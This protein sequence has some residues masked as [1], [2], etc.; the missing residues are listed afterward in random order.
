MIPLCI[1][2]IGEEELAL[3]EQV[4]K[5]GWLTHGLYNEQ[6]EQEFA[7]YLG[8]KR[9]ISMNSCTSALH[10]AIEAQG[11]T[12]EVI[13]PSFTFV[14]SAN[15]VITGG[16]TPVFADIEYETC[17]VDPQSIEDKLTPQTE[18]IM[19]VHFGG[20]SC[21]M[22]EIMAIAAK[23][24]LAVIEDAAETIG[25]EYKGRKVGSFATGC[26]SFFPTKNITTG[27]GG[28]LTTDDESLA[29]KVRAYVGHGISKREFERE[30][31]E[32]PWF[33][34]ATYAGYNFRMS[35]LLAAI[36]VVQLKKLDDMNEKRRQHAVYLKTKLADIEEIDLPVEAEHCKHVYQMFTIKVKNVDRNAFVRRLREKGIGASVHFDPPAHLQGYYLE[37]FGRI[38]LPVTEEVA[39]SIVTLPLYPQLNADELDQIAEAVRATFVELKSGGR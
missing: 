33:R 5:S 8:V 21:R 27:E 7:A 3:V 18:A 39:R 20:Q 2:N 17:N 1:P 35:N 11:I 34:S 38:R 19:P 22:D 14:A 23:H 36:G 37:R 12:G 9:A 29:N 4:L 16:A 30:R 10:L 26:F 13:V 28:M 31:T 15:A 32:R 24:G 6:L 25:G